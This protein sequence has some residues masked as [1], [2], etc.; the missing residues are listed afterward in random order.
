MAG[1]AGI[2]GIAEGHTHTQ[3]DGTVARPAEHYTQAVGTA[4]G[5]TPV[6]DSAARR[7]TFQKN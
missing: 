7:T 5:R 1:I 3:A 4:E 6:F 2:V